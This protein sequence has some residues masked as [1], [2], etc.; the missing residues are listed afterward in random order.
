[1]KATPSKLSKALSELCSSFETK[2]IEVIQRV[3]LNDPSPELEILQGDLAVAQRN[4]ARVLKEQHN[5]CTPLGRL[6]DELITAILQYGIEAQH[7]NLITGNPHIFPAY[8]LCTRWRQIAI[9]TPSLWSRVVL[10]C[11]PN[12]FR[13]VRDRSDNLLLKTYVA[14]IESASAINMGFLGEALRQIIPRIVHL[15]ITWHVEPS[16][17]SPLLEVLLSTDLAWK[18]FSALKVLRLSDAA[19]FDGPA[20][21][22]NMNAPLLRAMYFCG[23][24]H[25]IPR[26]FN[27]LTQVE[28]N[29]CLLPIHE[30]L[31]LLGDFPLLEKCAIINH[32][33]D[34]DD[35]IHV[36]HP[37]ILLDKLQVL[38]VDVLTTSAMHILL[39]HLEVPPS[40]VLSLGTCEDTLADHSLHDL[41]GL[42]LSESVQLTIDGDS[43]K[44]K[45]SARSKLRGAVS[46]NYAPSRMSF[47]EIREL[48]LL[49]SRAKQLSVL[50]IQ[51]RNLPSLADLIQAL[52]IWCSITC[53]RVCTQEL[54]FERLLTALEETSDI[55]CPLLRTID[56]VG[57]RFSSVRMKRF[58]EF[59]QQKGVRLEELRA[60]K[61][62]STSG[63]DGLRYLLDRVSEVDS[64]QSLNI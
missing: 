26:A 17:D 36:D 16:E 7:P 20:L 49:A 38:S 57:T 44:I 18:E 13:L 11:S 25:R 62:Y 64:A 19:V 46:V 39:R 28:F 61:G 35:R 30:I 33:A 41:L 5:L 34:P 29:W 6:P 54:D 42:C 27:H 43:R 15:D 56:C 31:S 60:S 47:T 23:P 51:F 55:V 10:P 37:V 2:A 50:D 24:A 22:L 59:R 1:M 58:L 40:A 9:H 48:P 53:I 8:S 12:L 14:N 63:L 3:N 45:Y 52:T 4:I 21:G 32:E